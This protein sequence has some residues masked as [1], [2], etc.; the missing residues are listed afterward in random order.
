[1]V[2]IQVNQLVGR[3]TRRNAGRTTAGGGSDI[4][5]K[6]APP[7]A[8][9]PDNLRGTWDSVP[10]LR[11]SGPPRDDWDGIGGA[12]DAT[13]VTHRGDMIWNQVG[14]M[15]A[16]YYAFMP[17]ITCT[18]QEFTNFATFMPGQAQHWATWVN[19]TSWLGRTSISQVRLRLVHQTVVF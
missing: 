12:M 14:N 11:L 3:W 13:R 4:S 9:P 15:K 17:R 19:V 7:N 18:A 16:R 1:M 2:N 6:P 10:D 5:A 8:S